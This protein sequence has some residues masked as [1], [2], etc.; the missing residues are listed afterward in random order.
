MTNPI[1]L[2]VLDCDELASELRAEYVCYGSMFK[3]FLEGHG[4]RME[5]QRFDVLE[6][7]FPSA[8]DRCDAY[9]ITGSKTG[10]YDE[11]SWLRPLADFI[12]QSFDAH[13]RMIGVCFG[14]QMLAHSLGG[15]ADKSKKGWG[16][17][18]MVH[19]SKSSP[20]WMAPM[21]ERLALL[22]SHQDQVHRPPQDARVL[23]GSDF[24]PNGAYWIPGRVLAFQGHPE[25]TIDYSRRLMTLRRERYAPGQYE[26]ALQSLDQT[27]HADAVARWMLNFIN[28]EDAQ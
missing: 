26:A 12:G 11:A 1:T 8:E 23:Y 25:F 6:H 24:C 9:L 20:K 14:H 28:G 27:L 5:F 4:A 2:G 18:A 3:R 13:K 16:V 15:H 10:V 19:E 17:G 7:Q 21:P 22:Y